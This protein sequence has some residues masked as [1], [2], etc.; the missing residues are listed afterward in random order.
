MIFQR[1]LI[2]EFSLIAIAVVGVLLAIILTRLLILLLGRAA[3]GEVLPEAVIGLIAFGILNYLPVLLGIAVFAAV[4]LA[5]TRSY[6]DSE[7]TV[8]FTSGLSIA[9]W[10]K[11]VLQFSIP[12][13]LVCALLSLWISPWSQDRSV[14]YQ[15]LLQS[16]DEVSSV[17]PG[18]FR[19]SRSS[20]RVFFVDKISEGDAEVNNVFVQSTQNDRM[21]VMVAKRG[22]IE[23]AENGD[24]FVVLLDGRRYEGTPGTLDYR[25]VDFDRYAIRIEPREAKREAPQNKAKPTIE[26]LEEATAPTAAELHW[27][28][29]QPLAVI[30]MGLFAIPLA[31][32]N[33]RSGRSW[34]ILLAVL[35]YALYSNLLSIFQAWTAQGK[36]PAWL[37]LWPVHVAMA[38]ILL[39][40]FSR[41]LFTFRT[42]TLGK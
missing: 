38:A 13:A 35:V 30:I 40:L 4:L 28:I 42:L 8:W 26:L 22:F 36:L 21:G 19:E 2:R 41:Q 6:R 5:L 31:F 29:A 9:A 18:V 27:R 20:D 33:P 10:V 15:R 23:T 11:P 39:I 16:R 12:V 3:G 37:G 24:R 1:S 32:V 7:M 17:T 34:N 25:T 14:E